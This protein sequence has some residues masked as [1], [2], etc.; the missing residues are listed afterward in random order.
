MAQMGKKRHGRPKEEKKIQ[1]Q[2]ARPKSLLSQDLPPIVS[3]I[4]RLSEVHPTGFEPVT[5]GS[6]DRWEPP[7]TQGKTGFSC[8]CGGRCGGT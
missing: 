4:Q 2:T 7:E 1:I 8:R 6:V 3:R 5:F